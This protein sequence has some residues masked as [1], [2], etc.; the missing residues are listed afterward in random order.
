M[1]N[2]GVTN[3]NKNEQVGLSS[4]E[5]VRIAPVV[6]TPNNT[7]QSQPVLV[8]T[9]N[10]MMQNTN[11]L[12][13]S[14][15]SVN[16]NTIQQNVLTTS[17]TP[18]QQTNTMQN[19]AT[20]VQNEQVHPSQSAL[21]PPPLSSDGVGKNATQKKKRGG[22]LTFIFILII[23]GLVAYIYYSSKNYMIVLRQLQYEC[24]PIQGDKKEIDLDLNSTLVKDL[25]SKVSTN[26]REDLAQPQFNDQ[27]K[28]YLAYR[29]ILDKDKYDSNCNLFSPVSMEPYRCEES[30]AFVP[31]A[32]KEETL[33]HEFRKLFG[34]NTDISL[35]NIQLGNSC[36][37]GYQ[38]ISDR[39]EFVQGFCNQQTATSYKATK[40]LVEAKSMGATIVLIEEVKYHENERMPLPDYLKSGTYK[41]TFRL[42]MNYNYVFLDKRYEEKY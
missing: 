1:N 16:A 12:Q 31:K 29:Q 8:N 17:N 6:E 30:T 19:V 7:G 4:M 35:Q 41:Y 40:T 24:S 14:Y 20:P 18:G 10:Q 11:A 15:P 37:V 26:I 2:N 9:S 42:D 27:M 32:F 13:G 33:R 23:I 25:Y 39:G 38:Y 34:E 21:T 3:S 5:G 36:L 28:L 22:K